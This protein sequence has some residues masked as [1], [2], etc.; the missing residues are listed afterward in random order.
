MFIL[1]LSEFFFIVF[2][3]NGQLAVGVKFCDQMT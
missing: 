2:D 1:M 3:R